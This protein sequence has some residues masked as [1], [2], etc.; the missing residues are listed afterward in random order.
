MSKLYFGDNLEILREFEPNSIDL[1]CTD[2]PFN[3]G[4]NYNIFLTSSK[5][6]EKAFEDIW[7]WDD[8]AQAGRR[9]IEEKAVS[10]DVY[11][12]LNDAL[13]GYDLVLQRGV[14][15]Y[16]GSMRAYLA[17]MGS[18]LVELHRVLSL[19]GSLYLHC[20][21]NASHYLKGVLDAIFGD[22]HF[23]NDIVWSHQGT[24]IQP[25]TKYPR[26]H[27]NLLFYT[28]T[29][30]YTFN[31]LHDNENVTNQINYKRWRKYLH[32]N[33]IYGCDMPTHDAR[34]A[35]YL[36][37][38][39]K[40]HGREPNDNDVVLEIDGG[41]LGTVQ[42][43]KVVDPKA[44]EYLDYPTQKPRELYERMIKA[45]SNVGN[46]VLDP[47]CGCGTTIDAA[48]TLKRDWIG[49]D[50]TILALDPMQKRMKER[51]G[52][53]PSINY[54]IIG[55]PTNMQ[56]VRKL[57]GEQNRRHDFA[58][59]AVTRIGLE[60][61]PDTGDGGFDGTGKAVIWN[62]RFHKDIETPV[63]AEVKSGNFTIKDVRAF[64]HSM[65]TNQA[66]VGIFITIKPISSGMKQIQEE[67]GTFEHNNKTYNRL[68]FWQIDD[69]YFQNPDSLNQIIQLP[70]TI[71]PQQ[72]SERHVGDQQTRFL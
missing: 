38:F 63:I 29:S 39:I 8:A 19:K 18:R 17:F 27:D 60:P 9:D 48:E 56:E 43:I 11:R 41:R 34:F 45:S 20:D 1:I 47:F 53:N 10:D 65:K 69:G 44:A 40:T 71:E 30:N 59:W 4:R 5:A 16:Q 36:K 31:I 7:T 52:L 32:G 33:T 24:W 2:P 15:G 26:R 67:M 14:G 13:K 50:L 46:I 12:R 54:E 21:P 28:K 6:Q 55:Y 62:S 57:V 42:Y 70:W 22:E 66:E 23:R 51:H 3:S 58:N 68:Q 25:A 37:R 64:C 35:P 61:T 49:I 72:K